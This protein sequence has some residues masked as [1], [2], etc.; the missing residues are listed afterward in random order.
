MANEKLTPKE[1]ISYLEKNGLKILEAYTPHFYGEKGTP[2]HAGE[3]MVIIAQKEKGGDK[4][5]VSA[6]DLL[7]SSDYLEASERK[8]EVAYS[9]GEF[10]VLRL[11]AGD[12]SSDSWG[13]TVYSRELSEE[14][15][16]EIR[17]MGI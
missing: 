4:L 11:S 9:F 14:L 16:D 10:R 15:K 5:I 12:Q 7:S 13:N 8:I 1:I 6:T 2:F 17:T 3:G